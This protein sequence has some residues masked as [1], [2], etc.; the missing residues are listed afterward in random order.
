MVQEDLQ[1]SKSIAITERYLPCQQNDLNQKLVRKVMAT[2]A[3]LMSI[4][5]T[6]LIVQRQ[7]IEY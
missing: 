6:L 4:N 7:D 2:T 5:T 1:P 3:G